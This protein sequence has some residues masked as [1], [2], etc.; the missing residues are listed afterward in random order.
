MAFVQK[1]NGKYR[2]RYRGPDGKERSQSFEK[3]RDA[4]N[5]LA[6]QKSS[7]L[8]GSYVDPSL[9]RK[10]FE[11]YVREFLAGPTNWRDRTLELNVGILDNHLLPRFGK[12]QLSKLDR[13]SVKKLISDLS[14]LSP[15]TIRNIVKCLRVILNEAVDDG[16]IAVNPCDKVR[17]P[18]ETTKEMLFLTHEQ[19]AQLASNIHPQYSPLVFTAAYVGLRW[20]ELAGLGPSQINWLRKS[21]TINRQL[22]EVNGKLEFGVPKTKKSTRTVS[23]PESV[24]EMLSQMELTGELV[25][26]TVTGKPMRRSNFRKTWKRAVEMTGLP[27]SFTFHELRHTMAAL[28][29]EAGAHPKTICDRLGHS[30]ITVTMDRYGH[31]FESQDEALAKK[32]DEGLR[33]AAANM[34][35]RKIS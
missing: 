25:F 5:W 27:S 15:S 32:L 11:E 21:I 23:V 19:V 7:M 28:S 8:T 35:P 14:H 6:A 16:L 10:T 9:G 29:I 26:T 20:G 13:K 22:V 18:A 34:R 17:L 4:E 33:A 1:R 2:A 30:S 31:L 24:L 12:R 3:K